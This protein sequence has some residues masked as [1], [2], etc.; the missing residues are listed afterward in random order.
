MVEVLLWAW[1]AWV[2]ANVGLFLLAARFAAPPDSPSFNGFVV[3]VPDSWRLALTGPEL[4]AVV[5]HERGHRDLGHV[6]IN[7]LL[8][9]CLCPASAERRRRQELAADDCA[10]DP[11]ALASALV[12]MSRHPFDLFRAA[13][14]ASRCLESASVRLANLTPGTGELLKRSQ[15]HE[16]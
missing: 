13:R 12:K 10:V 8:L 15:D 7:L 14:L 11:R 1:A 16:T 5:Q 4:E 3:R 9:C 2:V 6:W